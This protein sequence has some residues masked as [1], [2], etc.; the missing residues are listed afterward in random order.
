[1]VSLSFKI[2]FLGAA[3][4]VLLGLGHVE[5]EPPLSLEDIQNYGEDFA[6]KLLEPTKAYYQC[7]S[8]C[9]NDALQEVMA[10][11]NGDVRAKIEAIPVMAAIK[12]CVMG[13]I[14]TFT[15][16]DKIVHYE[17]EKIKE[18]RVYQLTVS[19]FCVDEVLN[20]GKPFF[21][22]TNGKLMPLQVPI[23]QGKLFLCSISNCDT[24]YGSAIFDAFKN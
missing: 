15:S 10:P 4:I 16:F 3:A 5:A 8:N 13:K 17:K 21:G 1:M 7:R 19:Q 6:A 2:T 20:K 11:K 14:A 22:S 9:Y 24:P 18:K 23:V 12:S